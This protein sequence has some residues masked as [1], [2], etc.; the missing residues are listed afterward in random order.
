MALI[1]FSL[2]S[3]LLSNLIQRVLNLAVLSLIV[4]ATWLYATELMYPLIAYI[5]AF[6]GAIVMLFLSVVLML[7]SSVISKQDLPS[8]VLCS[9]IV[10]MEEASLTS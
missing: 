8:P 10:V 6:L 9:T 2:C 5:I 3:N 7:P 1:T 4:V